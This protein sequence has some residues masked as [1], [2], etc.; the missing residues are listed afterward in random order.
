MRRIRG[1]DNQSE[2]RRPD[3]AEEGREGV[4]GGL[5]TSPREVKTDL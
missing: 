5:L 1:A 2:G 3:I 4:G